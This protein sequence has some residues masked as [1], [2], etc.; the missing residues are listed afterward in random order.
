MAENIAQV[1]HYKGLRAAVLLALKRAQPLAAAD[2]AREL[3][4]SVNAIRHHLKEL[5]AE[6]LIQY[7]REQRGVGAP[8]LA[9]RLSAQG[10]ALFPRRYEEAL[11]LMLDR[12]VSKEGRQAAVDLFEEHFRQLMA[13]ARVDLA[14]VDD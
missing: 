13:T 5:Q 11:T 14:V 1:A 3:G 4:V 8:T 12:L 6:S 10:E 7:G 9:Y 2:L